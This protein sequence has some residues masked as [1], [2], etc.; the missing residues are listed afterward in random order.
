MDIEKPASVSKAREFI[1]SVP[2]HMDKLVHKDYVKNYEVRSDLGDMFYIHIQVHYPFHYRY[3]P[4]SANQSF[5]NVSF[6]N[7]QVGYDCERTPLNKYSR[8]NK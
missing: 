3:Q 5:T 1:W 7:P 2:I 6:P 8:K 4:I